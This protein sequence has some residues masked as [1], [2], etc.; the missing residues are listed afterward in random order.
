MNRLLGE[1]TRNCK[2]T[3]RNSAKKNEEE[4]TYRGNVVDA[5]VVTSPFVGQYLGH[6]FNSG[7]GSSRVNLKEFTI[8]MKRGGDVNDGATILLHPLGISDTRSSKRSNGV[9]LHDGSESV[10]RELSSGRKEVTSST[11]DEN[12]KTTKLLNDGVDGSFDLLLVADIHADRDALSTS[13]FAEFL[14]SLGQILHVSASDGNFA[15][16]VEHLF[17]HDTTNITTTSSDKGS[18]AGEQIAAEERGKVR[19]HVE[20]KRNGSDEKICAARREVCF[21]RRS[22]QGV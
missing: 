20:V 6:A 5:N 2:E 8:P 1:N 3:P 19:R 16:M 11:I 17:N 14:R 7:L 9:D 18:F 22:K 13:L 4:K 21:K 10:C 12:I 15:P